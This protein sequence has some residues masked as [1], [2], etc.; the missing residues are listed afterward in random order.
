MTIGLLAGNSLP[1]MRLPLPMLGIFDDNNQDGLNAPKEVGLY[2][3][4][5]TLL[6]SGIVPGGTAGLSGWSI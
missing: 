1:I 6:A 2:D 3:N 5:G 4:F